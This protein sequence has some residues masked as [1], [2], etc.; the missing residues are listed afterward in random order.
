MSLYCSSSFSCLAVSL[1]LS[2]KIFLT[3][4]SNIL[5]IFN[6]DFTGTDAALPIAFSVNHNFSFFSFSD[7][8]DLNVSSALPPNWIYLLTVSS[9]V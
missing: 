9:L 2:Q 4:S 5:E 3:Q 7:V 6:T 1:S 8:R